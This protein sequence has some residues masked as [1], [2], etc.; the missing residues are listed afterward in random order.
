MHMFSLRH[1][2]EGLANDSCNCLR[3][4]SPCGPILRH[5]WCARI[6]IQTEGHFLSFHTN[7]PFNIFLWSEHFVRKHCF[8]EEWMD[9]IETI[10]LDTFFSPD[11][12]LAKASLPTPISR[13][14][15]A[16]YANPSALTDTISLSL[17]LSILTIFYA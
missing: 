12:F 9:G 4:A 15:K 11:L 16:L 2:Y 6:V 14:V 7:F 17:S 1:H 10:P 13:Y 3:S 8:F 5:V